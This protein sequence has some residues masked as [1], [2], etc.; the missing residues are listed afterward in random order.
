VDNGVITGRYP[1]Y[2][3]VAG[4]H[5]TAK[6]GFLAKSDGTCGTGNVKFQLNYKESG[7]LNLSANGRKLV[8]VR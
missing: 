2:T 1:A 7:V 4:E 5:F 6:I 3:V 8:M